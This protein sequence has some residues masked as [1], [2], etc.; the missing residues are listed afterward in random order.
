MLINHERKVSTK[1]AES[2]YMARVWRLNES[3]PGEAADWFKSYVLIK[4]G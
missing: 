4:D 1:E 3:S 2:A